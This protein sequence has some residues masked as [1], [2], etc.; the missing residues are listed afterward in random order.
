MSTVRNFCCRSAYLR[1]AFRIGKVL[2]RI[3][4]RSGKVLRIGVSFWA[5]IDQ[6]PTASMKVQSAEHMKSEFVRSSMQVLALL[7]F[8]PLEA[9]ARLHYSYL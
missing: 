9:W 7:C 2:L 3:A 1:I 4:F 8:P 5:T 6:T